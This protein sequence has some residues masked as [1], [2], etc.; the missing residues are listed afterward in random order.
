MTTEQEV[1]L[2]SAAELS[3]RHSTQAA[4]SVSLV[5]LSPPSSRT[6]SVS[7]TFASRAEQA[8]VHSNWLS[9]SVG[10]GVGQL[11][12]AH[13]LPVALPV[14]QKSARLYCA[15]LF[16]PP[17][18]LLLSPLRIMSQLTS[19]GELERQVTSAN[20]MPRIELSTNWVNNFSLTN[21]VKRACV[22]CTPSFSL[23]V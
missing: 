5:E 4:P 7:R 19:R 2:L 10:R 14:G 15:P 21:W 18:P 1:P 22:E 11:I 6:W 23:W 20:Q 8:G 9:F 13:K 17:P 16:P 3:L 12:K